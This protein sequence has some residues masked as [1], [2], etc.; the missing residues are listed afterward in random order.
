MNDIEFNNINK[1]LNFGHQLSI[2][3]VK[4]ITFLDF[5]PSELMGLRRY[6]SF[7]NRSLGKARFI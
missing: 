6:G 3:Y 1:L 2:V 4:F 5:S 7:L